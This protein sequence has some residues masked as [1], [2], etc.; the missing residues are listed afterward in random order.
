MSQRDFEKLI[1]MQLANKWMCYYSLQVNRKKTEAI[2]FGPKE[3][4]SRVDT[5][6]LLIK[7]ETTDQAQTLGVIMDSDLNFQG[8]IRKEQGQPSIKWKTFLKLKD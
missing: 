6:F 5:Q 2:L 8:H 1:Q 3:E 4:R 7:L